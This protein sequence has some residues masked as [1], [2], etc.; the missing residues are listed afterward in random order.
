MKKFIKRFFYHLNKALLSSTPIRIYLI[1]SIVR[2]F[3]IGSFKF[4][5]D[6]D[7]HLYPGYAYCMYSAAIQAKSL[8]ITKISAI[9][10]GVAGG[11]GLIAMEKYSHKIKSELGVDISIFGFDTGS[12]MPKPKDYRD[13]GYFWY[14]TEFRMDYESLKKSLTNTSLLIGNVSETVAQFIQN[15]EV[16]PIGFI[17]FDL[18]YFSS[19]KSSFEIFKNEHHLFLPRVEAYMDDICSTELLYASTETGVLA[20][21]NEFN[22][23]NTEIK[24]LRKEGVSCFRYIPEYWN[25]KIF[26]LHRFSHPLYSSSVIGFS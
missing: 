16:P 15:Y 9:E 4:Q 18:D 25:N 2:K 20:A 10:F 23:K 8:G 24:I 13:Q 5:T 21:I 3:D 12:G 7:A 14:E 17:A 1:R 22:S 6:I 11:A 19:T 26:A